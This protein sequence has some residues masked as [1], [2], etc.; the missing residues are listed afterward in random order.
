M[1]NTVKPVIEVFAALAFLFMGVQLM[2][3]VFVGPL[4]INNEPVST[5]LMLPPAFLQFW[6]CWRFFRSACE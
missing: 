6:A 3:V 1:M 2:K 4:V 5:L